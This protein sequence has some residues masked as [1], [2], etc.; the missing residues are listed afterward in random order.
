M[1]DDHQSE[2]TVGSPNV[3]NPL[4]TNRAAVTPPIDE[5]FELLSD[6][7]RRRV[8]LYLRRSGVEVTE[9]SDLID[10]LASE[11]DA[12]DRDRLAIDLHHRHLPKLDDAGIVDYD[13]RSHTARYWGQPTVEKWAEH[14][15][16]VDGP[17]RA[18]S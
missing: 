8:C 14:V 16:A 2:G 18:E 7:R 4:G 6:S 3:T 5:V 10:A 12:V 1:R 17:E 11:D 15:E 13:P 9:L